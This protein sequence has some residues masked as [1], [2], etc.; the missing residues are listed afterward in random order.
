MRISFPDISQT[1]FDY[2]IECLEECKQPDAAEFG[3][4]HPY[5]TPGGQYGKQWWQLDSSLALAGYKWI[6]RSF[7]ETALLN[8]IESQKPDGRICLWGS[9][10]L[11]EYVSGNA[12]PKQRTGVSSLPKIFDIAYSIL[13]GSDDISLTEKTYNMLKKY[14]D[15]WYSDR[16]DIKTGLFSSVFEETFIPYLGCA[17]EYAAV[18]T[19]VELYVAL[20]YTSDIASR[21]NM[22]RESND[23]LQ[24]AKALKEAINT[25]LWNEE[26]GAYYPYNLKK[27]CQNE[28]LMASVF[29]PLR[30]NIASEKQ[31]ERLISLL[32]NNEHFN[33][34]TI[35][36]TSVSKMNPIFTT[37]VGDYQGNASW[38]GNVW[39]L[40]N[41]MAVRALL[42]SGE[43]ELAAELALKTIY[44][45]NSNCTEFINPF[46]GKGHG[47][48]KYAWTASQYIELIVEVIFG[49]GLNA[50][51]REITISPKLTEELKNKQLSLEGIR[52]C[53]NSYLDVFISQGNVR[54]NL[55]PDCNWRVTVS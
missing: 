10:I 37:T 33:W 1:D 45:F 20:I 32:K 13:N 3:F 52:I 23:L 6:D 43:S 5:F 38:S 53:G 19:N 44:L 49:I 47:V 42:D 2:A 11:P 41:E 54:W 51:K 31:K 22:E 30:M 40:I 24:N 48:K 12:M 39:S 7:A 9:D 55:S 14:I 50:E 36:L 34:N 29:F 16:Y 27:S 35:P 8:F 21:L 26:K 15:W 4:K 17:M 18:D 28:Q 46:D 25:Y